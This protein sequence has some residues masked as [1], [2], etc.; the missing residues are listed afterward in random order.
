M[1]GKLLR[2]GLA[3]EGAPVRN[4]RQAGDTKVSFW[5]DDFAPSADVRPTFRGISEKSQLHAPEK[6]AKVM[7]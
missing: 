4:G 7:N 1:G 6:N 2:G 5:K 3:I